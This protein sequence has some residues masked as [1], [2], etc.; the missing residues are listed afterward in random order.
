M[1]FSARALSFTALSLIA[2]SAI[3]DQIS[4]TPDI[5]HAEAKPLATD[6]AER[7][8]RWGL[9]EQ[10]WS[11]YQEI[12]R[13]PRGTWSPDLD[14]LTAL[15]VEARNDAER[16]RYAELQV[17][18]EAQRA[19][20]ELTYQKAYTDA[21]QRLYP[22]LMPVEGLGNGGSAIDARWALFVEEDCSS[23]ISKLQR[24]QARGT[25]IDIYLVG[26]QNDDEKVRAWA[27]N[28]GVDAERLQQRQLTLNHDRGLWFSL[29]ATGGLPA[30]YQQVD[31]RWQR[32]E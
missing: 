11:R 29:G 14:P 12:Q 2:C 7:A 1:I 10:E 16:S 32:I 22:G 13:G 21:W 5:E 27:R 6:V 31:G 24:L 23:C 8:E 28:A 18:L 15:G 9:T 17:K 30:V 4:T 26:S 20:G 3:A 25:P 19:E